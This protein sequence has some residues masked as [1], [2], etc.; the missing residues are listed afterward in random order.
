MND[1]SYYLPVVFILLMGFSM[2]VYAALDGYDLGVGLLMPF[3]SIEDRDIMIASIGPFWDANETWLV[4]GVGIL[5]VAFPKAHGIILSGLY[6]PVAVMLTGL[7]LRGVAFDFRAKAQVSHKNLWDRLFIIGSYLAALSQGYMLGRYIVGLED[8]PLAII[9]ACVSALCI[10]AAYTL[11]GAC[12]L[13]MKTSTQLQIFAIGWARKALPLTAIGLISVSVINPFVS[14]RIFDKWLQWPAT[15]LL[16]PLPA[17]CAYLL[18]RL[19]VTLQ[20]L[21]THDD[22][23]CW[24]PFVTTLGVFTL[25]FIGLAYSFYPYVVPDQLTVWEAA[26]ATESLSVIFKGV[27][28]VV[29]AILAYTIFSYRVFRGKAQR[30]TYH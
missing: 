19:H 6:L 26:S 12:W 23:G 29:P 15:V 11:I 21:P 1:P 8:T 30:L 22:S 17:L 9:F 2:L 18:Y 28:V 14:D 7:I 16:V 10:T 27:V 4:L 5:L 25:S 24:Q 3:A 20:K 13:I